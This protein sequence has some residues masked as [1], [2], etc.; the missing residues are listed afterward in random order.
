[1]VETGGY[2]ITFRAKNGSQ[3][4]GSYSD[5]LYPFNPVNDTI[6]AHRGAAAGGTRP[7]KAFD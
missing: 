6:N 2:V 3:S 7:K 1:M 4:Q 5:L